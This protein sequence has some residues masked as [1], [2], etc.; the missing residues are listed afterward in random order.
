MRKAIRYIVLE[1]QVAF[2]Y[3]LA[4]SAALF[5]PECRKL[6]QELWDAGEVIDPAVRLL[7]EQEELERQIND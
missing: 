5:Y 4:Y 6:L 2:W 3:A 1:V 7:R